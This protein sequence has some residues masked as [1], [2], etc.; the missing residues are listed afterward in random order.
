VESRS[1][2]EEPAEPAER[3][4]IDQQGGTAP[5][6]PGPHRVER[7][8]PLEELRLPTQ[9]L[10]DPMVEAERGERVALGHAR[11]GDQPLALRVLPQAL[12][13]ETA[14][15][16]GRARPVEEILDRPVR[17]VAVR[18]AARLAHPAVVDQQR[19]AGVGEPVGDFLD[20]RDRPVRD[21]GFL[22]VSEGDVVAGGWVP[23]AFDESIAVEPD[24]HL[25]RSRGRA[26]QAAERKVVHELVRQ[27]QLR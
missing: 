20:E 9:L 23:E 5:S 8:P 25:P 21:H 14:S 11:E 6:A 7:F 26:T 10:V 27:D 4:R 16:V 12:E 2:E 1:R 17:P 18:R 19:V 15:D 13:V 3:R 22:S 24:H